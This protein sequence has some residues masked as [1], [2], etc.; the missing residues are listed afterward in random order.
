MKSLRIRPMRTSDIDEWM[1]LYTEEQVQRNINH[2]GALA[3]PERLRA[4]V[5]GWLE[6]GW[7]DRLFYR[8]G[9]ARDDLVGF[10]RL[11]RLDWLSGRC[12]LTVMVAPRH[13]NRLGLLAHLSIYEFVYDTLNVR[14]IVHEVL[15]GNEMM[16]TEAH[17]RALA[18]AVTPDHCF[19]VGERRTCYWWAE[20][21]ADRAAFFTRNAER[22]A[23]VRQRLAG[24]D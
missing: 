2:D 6:S 10:A 13:R 16:R 5:I 7:P 17:Y 20:T 8:I 22:G 23:R 12:D 18:Q 11:S 21:R 4:T 19:T 15:S 24:R 1:A 3:G 14:V 9:T